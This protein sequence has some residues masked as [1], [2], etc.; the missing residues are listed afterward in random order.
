MKKL[1]RFLLSCTFLSLVLTGCEKKDND[2]NH[3]GPEMINDITPVIS[4]DGKTIS[5]GLFPQTNIDDSSLISALN[6]LTTAESNGWYLY[7]GEYYAKVSATPHESSY[8][9][10]NGT[11]IVSGTTYWFKCEPITWNVLNNSNGKYYIL[12][13]VLLDA[14]RYNEYYA[15]TKD[16]HYAN[17]YK[18]SEIRSWLNNDF[19]NSAFALGNSYIQ[20]TDVNNSASTT[21]SS[22]NQYACENTN[23]KV[24][25]PSYKDYINSSYGFS[26]STGSTNTRYCRT[27]DWARARGSYYYTSSGS[28]QYNGY[29]WTRSP[30]SDYSGYSWGVLSDGD[31]YFDFGG[32][33]HTN[34]SVRPAITITLP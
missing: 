7:E 9:F 12:S 18:Y 30:S 33:S 14:H 8:K 19:Y 29:Y 6:S 11:K 24:F 31:V 23:D 2:D 4:E 27:T 13:S 16:G 21:K 10:D 25:L 34:Y 26:T 1:S 22:S 3:E 17:N 15:G 20:T 28:F 5:Y 32:V